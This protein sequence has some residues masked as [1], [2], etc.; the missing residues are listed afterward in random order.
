VANECR[1]LDYLLSHEPDNIK[2]I[3]NAHYLKDH[4]SLEIS[5]GLWNPRISFYLTLKGDVPMNYRIE[6]KDGFTVYGIERV[7]STANGQNWDLVPAFWTEIVNNGEY[8]RLIKSTNL[9]SGG[10]GINL[11]NAVDSYRN[12]GNDTFPYMV[13]AFK[14]EKSD[15]E[16]YTEVN[17]PLAVWFF[18]DMFGFS[19]GNFVL[20][21]AAWKDIDGI[22]YLAYN[23]FF[24]AA[25]RIIPA[26]DNIIIPDLY[27]IVLHILILLALI[28]TLLYCL[29]T[30]TKSHF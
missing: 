14:T 3:G 5:N 13:F 4:D 15:T 16:G 27:H 6:Q 22:W 11:V 12:T 25:Y 23:K 30:R 2:K 29:K 18:L 26:S 21:E 20:V 17:V 9:S 8:D 1:I 19:A 28:F 24:A 10:D 7:I